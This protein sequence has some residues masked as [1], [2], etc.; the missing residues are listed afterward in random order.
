MEK[1]LVR[2]ETS[3][4]FMGVLTKGGEVVEVKA[5]VLTI[6]VIGVRTISSRSA[7]MVLNV[8]AGLHNVFEIIPDDPVNI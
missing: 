2:E 4:M 7:C 3:D 5:E 6:V 1:A 8:D